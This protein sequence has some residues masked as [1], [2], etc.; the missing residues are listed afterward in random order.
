[1][2]FETSTTPLPVR[3]MRSVR[4]SFSWILHPLRNHHVL[5]KLLVDRAHI[6]ELSSIVENA[7]HGWVRA[8]NYLQDSSLRPSIRTHWPNFHQHAIS[9]HRIPNRIRRDINVARNPR[10][11]LVTFRN[12]EAITIAVHA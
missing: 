6:V 9:V 2:F 4:S 3:R 8:P 1:M 12:D 7:Y 11:N 5:R 10:A